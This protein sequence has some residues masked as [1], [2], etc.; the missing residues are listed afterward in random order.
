MKSNMNS[1]FRII[2]VR[3]IIINGN[4]SKIYIN[5][6]HFITKKCNIKFTLKKAISSLKNT[7]LLRSL[8]MLFVTNQ[9]GRDVN[10]GRQLCHNFPGSFIYQDSNLT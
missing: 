4:I 5:K 3:I 1:S 10:N 7:A 9:S 2:I 8:S 6:T